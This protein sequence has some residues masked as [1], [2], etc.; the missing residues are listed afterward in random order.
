MTVAQPG[1]SESLADLPYQFF[2]GYM[3]LHRVL[4]I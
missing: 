4:H 2:D 3:S 1:R